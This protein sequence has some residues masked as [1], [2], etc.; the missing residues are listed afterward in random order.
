M[1]D[2]TPTWAAKSGET[3]AAQAVLTFVLPSFNPMRVSVS[4]PP[5]RLV[6]CALAIGMLF[7][8]SAKATELVY[9]PINP[10]FGGSPLNAG[11]LLALANAQNGYRAPAKSALQSFNDNL[12]Q[13]ILSRLSSQALTNLFG[14]N[15]NLVPGTYDT[16]AYSIE[17]T[18]TGNGVLKIITT[19]KST[20]DVVSFELGNSNLAT[21]P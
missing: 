2:K 21:G 8:G 5:Q 4:H 19:D 18:D 10:V 12:Q 11:G 16:G 17:V 14:K 6:V 1:T 9:T 20:G 15:S 3:T 7:V 13:A